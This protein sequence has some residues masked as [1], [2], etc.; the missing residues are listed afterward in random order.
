MK[1]NQQ[2]PK[3]L[4][5]V[6]ILYIP[7]ISL[8][9]LIVLVNLHTGIPLEIF[10]RDPTAIAGI[11]PFAGIISNIGILFWCIAASICLFS[12]FRIIYQQTNKINDFT[13]FLLFFGVTTSVLLLDDLFL[14]HE[15][16]AP[17]ILNLS[18]EKVFISYGITVLYGI[19]RFKKVIFQTEWVVLSLAFVFF[20]LSIL[21]DVAG[22]FDSLQFP[23]N[24][25]EDGFK[26]LGIV[27]WTSYFV[28]ASFQIDRES[29]V[30]SKKTSF[31][32]KK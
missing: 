21:M 5:I 17:K 1:N 25:I 13:L 30:N 2:L 22:F 10:T 32:V 19:I 6:T 28:L 24:F 26:L 9:S 23:R 4:M 12:F 16:I 7:I 15:T 27:S 3:I 14:F 29:V 18:E 8:L 20:A 31:L 11:S